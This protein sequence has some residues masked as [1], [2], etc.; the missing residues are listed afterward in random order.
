MEAYAMALRTRVIRAY[1]RGEGAQL[2]LA[3]RFEVSEQ[4]FQMLPRQ[5]RQRDS[6]APL[7]L[8][9]SVVRGRLWQGR[10]LGW[11]GP[12]PLR[13]GTPGKGRGAGHEAARPGP[14]T[15]VNPRGGTAPGHA[16]SGLC[17]VRQPEPRGEVSRLT[18]REE[19]WRR[20][21]ARR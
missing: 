16:A 3:A 19:I 12:G 4:R 8:F 5:R 18:R 20:Y 14:S 15:G 13:Q 10:V 6:I 7:V 21:A 9:K 1:D 2:E 11:G 17:R